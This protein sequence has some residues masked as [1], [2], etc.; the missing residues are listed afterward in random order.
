MFQSTTIVN[1]PNLLMTPKNDNSKDENIYLSKANTSSSFKENIILDKPYIPEFQNVIKP[2]LNFYYLFPLNENIESNKYLNFG[3][4]FLY[5]DKKQEK[6]ND[7]I[8]IGQKRYF[9]LNNDYLLFQNNIFEKSAFRNIEMNK[10]NNLFFK[11]GVKI[12]RIKKK[13]N[14]SNSIII[15]ETKSPDNLTYDINSN[16]N[17]AKKRKIF[18]SIN[19]IKIHNSNDGNNDEYVVEKKK[20]GRRRKNETSKKRMHDASD[21]DNILRKIQVH[22]LTFIVSFANDLI[23]AFIINNKELKFKSLSYDLKKTV[24]HTYVQYL[25]NKTIGEILQFDASSKN[26]KYNNS[27]NKQIFKKVCEISPYLTNFFNMSYLEFFSEYYFKYNRAFLFEGK[28]VNMSKNTRIFIDLIQKNSADAEKIMQ[29][30]INN[31]IETKNENNN[32]KSPMFIINNK[33]ES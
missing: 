24:N 29:I 26:K 17:I 23:A 7:I 1:A 25:K 13:I 20:R 9:N 33:K 21:Y 27:I 3:N 32:N 11:K 6:N 22:Y 5:S 14:L 15:N 19:Y 31:F 8:F 2:N 12:S 4:S 18:K 16:I 10:N 28:I 30:A